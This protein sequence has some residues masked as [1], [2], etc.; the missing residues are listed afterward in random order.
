MGEGEEGGRG[1][2]GKRERVG[3]Q[4]WGWG[5]G[6]AAGRAKRRGCFGGGKRVGFDD[7]A[8]HKFV[9]STAETTKFDG[10]FKHCQCIYAR[11]NIHAF[12]E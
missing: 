6:G 5:G 2:G 1:G 8:D 10:V 9:H 11:P 3:V 7:I 12:P 4:G